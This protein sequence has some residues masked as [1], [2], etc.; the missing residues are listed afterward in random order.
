MIES[1]S[2]VAAGIALI[3]VIAS[4]I[5]SLTATLLSTRSELR[6]I[7]TTLRNQYASMLLERRLNSYSECYYV[8]STFI[9]RARGFMMVDNPLTYSDVQA[10]S[11]RIS[12][13]DSRNALLLSPQSMKRIF[14]LRRE[15]K[16]CLDKYPADQLPSALDYSELDKLALRSRG[17]EKGLRNDIAIYEVEKHEQKEFVEFEGLPQK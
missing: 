10:F 15:L 6:K 4:V 13:W 5:A 14:D 16:D 9:K 1:P 7:K 11:D 2:I 12:D 3:G 8:L 17:L